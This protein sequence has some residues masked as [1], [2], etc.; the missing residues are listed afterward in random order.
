[1]NNNYNHKCKMCGCPM[2]RDMNNVYSRTIDGISNW[3]GMCGKK[4]LRKMDNDELSK[5]MIEGRLSHLLDLAEK[6]NKMSIKPS[7]NNKI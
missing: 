7:D 1:M 4:C 2:Y 5:M 3:L 6:A